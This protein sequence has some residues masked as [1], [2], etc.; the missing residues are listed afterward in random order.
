VAEPSSG[1]H[2]RVPRAVA[3][4]LTSVFGPGAAGAQTTIGIGACVL[5]LPVTVDLIAMVSGQEGAAE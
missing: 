5:D 3:E 4:V 1:A 2:S